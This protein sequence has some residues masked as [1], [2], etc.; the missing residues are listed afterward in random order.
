M[1]G[2]VAIFVKTVG[3]SPLKTR[4]AKTIGVANAEGFH[5]AA[6]RCVAAATKD[7]SLNTDVDAY[8]A[9]AEKEALTSKSW[10]DLPCVWQGEGGLGERMRTIYQQLLIKYDFVLLIGADIPQMEVSELLKA[11]AYLDNRQGKK[12]VYGP[13]ADGG[14]WLFGSNFVIPEAIWT[15]VIYSQPET[16][17]HFLNA[18][19][20]LAD[21]KM[22]GTLRDVDEV[23]DLKALQASLLALS[24]PSE[25]QKKLS[26]FLQTII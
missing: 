22:L 12:L 3:L 15:D 19:Q 16:G 14:F 17:E 25:A 23:A 6:T 18:I 13:S 8:Y 11:S 1:Q 21:L 5:L 10:Q 2:A 20:P 24:E 9:V 7:L 26:H 4:L